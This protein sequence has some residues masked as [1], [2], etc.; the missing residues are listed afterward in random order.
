MSRDGQ[1][2]GPLAALLAF[3]RPQFRPKKECM[4]WTT[5]TRS[6]SI[7]GSDIHVM[8]ATPISHIPSDLVV[9]HWTSDGE[10]SAHRDVLLLHNV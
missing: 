10:S 6:G 4:S 7:L 1:A 3:G 2:N 9:D 5:S 8:L